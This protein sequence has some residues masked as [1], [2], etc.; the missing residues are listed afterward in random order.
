MRSGS[1]TKYGGDVALVEA[2]ALDEVQLHA[3]GLRLLDGDDAVLADLVHGLGDLLADLVVGRGDRGD[4]GDLALV[5]D[6][7]GLVLDGL[8]GPLDGELDA[9]LQR[10]RVGAG[11]DVAQAF[12][13][14]GVREHGRG[15]RAVTGHVV[16]LLG[17]LLDQF[18]PD[19][20]VR[21]LELD[22]LG[23]GD[24]VVGDR[25]RAPL[26]LEDHV[27]PLGTEGDPDR[28]R[29]LV[30]PPLQGAPRLLVERDE[31]GC[32]PASS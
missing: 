13:D 22:L 25:G 14:H 19:P 24:A 11:G 26:L 7:L 1:V 12:L 5:L 29:E 27:A 30:H 2:H 18:G 3:E 23:D 28:V 32:H 15:R 31:L 17:D 6:V 16:G 20:L 9:A 4:V 21:V 8:D 10:H